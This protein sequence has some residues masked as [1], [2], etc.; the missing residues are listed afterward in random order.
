MFFRSVV[1]EVPLRGTLSALLIHTVEKAALCKEELRGSAPRATGA[2][3]LFSSL[4]KNRKQKNVT[5]CRV[6]TERRCCLEI[7]RSRSRVDRLLQ[8]DFGK[9]A[10]VLSNPR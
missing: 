4:E 1:V 7:T 9:K 6:A 8:R 5:V 2:V 3:G 10:S